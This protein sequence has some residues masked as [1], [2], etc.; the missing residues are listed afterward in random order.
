MEAQLYK[1]MPIALYRE[2]MTLKNSISKGAGTRGRISK[3]NPEESTTSTPVQSSSKAK[4]TIS[5]AKTNTLSNRLN[6]LSQQDRQKADTILAKISKLGLTWD[7]QGN[8]AGIDHQSC[9][10]WDFILYTVGGLVQNEAS[11]VTF[12]DLIRLARIPRRLLSKLAK[13]EI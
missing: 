5:A 1:V 3:T 2:L 12:K 7:V 13:M 6:Q 8:F 11:L 4:P 10:I 9:N